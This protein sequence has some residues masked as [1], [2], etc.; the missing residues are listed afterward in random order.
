[1]QC[2]DSVE[3]YN[4]IKRMTGWLDY[5]NIGYWWGRVYWFCG[6]EAYN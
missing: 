3:D 6:G 5:E 4:L 2:R 1:M